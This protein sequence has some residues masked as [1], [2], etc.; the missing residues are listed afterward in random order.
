VNGE[1]EKRS[2]SKKIKDLSQKVKKMV[3]KERSESNEFLSSISKTS[4]SS[5]DSISTRSIQ[6]KQ[7]K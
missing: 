6:K 4:H 5:V 2:K 3:V 1:G 7:M